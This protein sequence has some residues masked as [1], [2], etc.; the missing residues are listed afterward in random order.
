MLKKCVYCKTEYET[1]DESSRRVCPKCSKVQNGVAIGCGAIV[2]FIV[3]LVVIGTL[4]SGKPE[5]DTELNAW[6]Y[7]RLT[8]QSHMREPRSAKVQKTNAYKSDDVWHFFG[9]VT[10]KNMLGG[11]S[12]HYFHVAVS[13]IP[14]KP[15]WQTSLCELSDPF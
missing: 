11:E 8:V 10:G 15:Y 4:S 14:E 5:K 13:H 3:L 12:K 6:S 2:L 9:V 7:A 1:T